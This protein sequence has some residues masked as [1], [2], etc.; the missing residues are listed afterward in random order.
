VHRVVKEGDAF[1]IWVEQSGG[2]TIK[3]ES[4]F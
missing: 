3:E 4:A 2:L 1:F